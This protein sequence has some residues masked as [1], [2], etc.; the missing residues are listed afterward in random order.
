MSELDSKVQLMNVNMQSFMFI[1]ATLVSFDIGDTP[2]VSLS[3]SLSLAEMEN[4]KIL[5]RNATDCLLPSA[6]ARH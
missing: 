5:L 3:L 6:A 4:G 1:L 2:S